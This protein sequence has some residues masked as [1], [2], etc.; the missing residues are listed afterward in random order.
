MPT[1]K[2][3]F[4]LFLYKLLD[5]YIHKKQTASDL[6]TVSQMVLLAAQRLQTL[7]Q[8]EKFMKQRPLAQRSLNIDATVWPQQQK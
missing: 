7:S 4:I 3:E 5:A 8:A 1:V 2:E 6:P